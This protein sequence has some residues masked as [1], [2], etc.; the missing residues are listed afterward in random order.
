MKTAPITKEVAQLKAKEDLR[1]DIQG[2]FEEKDKTKRG[3]EGIVDD[4][5]QQ[6]VEESKLSDMLYEASLKEVPV[7]QGITPMFNTLFVTAK[8]N[9]KVSN[10]IIISQTMVGDLEC[11]YQEI[12]KVAAVGP[13]V[14]QAK[15]GGEVCI[16]FKNF[17]KQQSDSMAQ[18]VNK[19]K[20]LEVPIITIDDV[21]YIHVSERDLK[22]TK[23]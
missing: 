21:D 17:L 10:G 7:P 11:D 19:V 2:F 13:Q 15:V 5:I 20:K 12:Q 4:M 8:L 1:Q 6:S 14:Q 3:T 16:D 22:Y 18:K 9:K 23:S